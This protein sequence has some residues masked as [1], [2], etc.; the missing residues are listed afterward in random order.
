[1]LNYRYGIK[2]KRLITGFNE[3]IA[4]NEHLLLSLIVCCERRVFACQEMGSCCGQKLSKLVLLMFL[5]ANGREGERKY[6]VLCLDTRKMLM[7]LTE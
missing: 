7:S 1:M 3:N 2:N 4:L 6:F 5:H